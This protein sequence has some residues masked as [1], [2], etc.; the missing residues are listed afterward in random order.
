[1]LIAFIFHYYLNPILIV[2]LK[3]ALSLLYYVT[4]FIIMFIAYIITLIIYTIG[5]IFSKRKKDKNEEELD[6]GSDSSSFFDVFK[7]EK[8]SNTEDENSSGGID[9]L[10]QMLSIN[11]KKQ[12]SSE[13]KKESKISTMITNI[14]NFSMEDFINSK[15]IN[16]LILNLNQKK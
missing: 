8:S 4:Y 13:K 14:S 2:T 11:T 9:R 6:D 12:T 1:M 16:I 3:L 10:K 7:F 15:K 5:W